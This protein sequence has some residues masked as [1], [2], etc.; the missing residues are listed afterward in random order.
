MKIKWMKMEWIEHKKSQM[1]HMNFDILLNSL[2]LV[3]YGFGNH[4]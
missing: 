3:F 4:L 1:L 2:T